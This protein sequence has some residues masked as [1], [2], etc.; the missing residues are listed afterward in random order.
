[1]TTKIWGE[2]IDETKYRVISPSIKDPVASRDV[3][4]SIDVVQTV[5][6]CLQRKRIERRDKSKGEGKD[7]HE[8]HCDETLP[9]ITK[10]DVFIL[11]CGLRPVKDV[12]FLVKAFEAW[13]S[14]H[15]PNSFFLI[16]GPP[17]DP[18][19]TSTVMDQISNLEGVLYSPAVDQV[20]LHQL[21]LQSVA[22]VN[23]SLSE[24]LSNVLMEAMMLKVPLI[25]KNIEGNAS[26]IE[27]KKTGLLFDDPE[28]FVQLAQQL[29]QDRRLS[30]SL[31]QQAF[32]YAQEHHSVA[33]E[34]DMYKNLVFDLVS[35]S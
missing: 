15:S 35:A 24:G 26:I 14:V 12:L 9:I 33:K 32:E 10:P 30:E 34:R 11:P 25:V 6:D 20:S 17:L 16:I 27:D 19:Y 21:M 23:S 18:V 22:V 3:P 2:R 5:R 8:D 28:Q 29:L 1:M 13:R 7:D 4:F 31:A